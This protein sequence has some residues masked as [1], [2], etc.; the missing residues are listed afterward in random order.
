MSDLVAG[1]DGCRGG[2]IVALS[3][4]ARPDLD[5]FRI[6]TLDELF[7]RFPDINVVAVDMPI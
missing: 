6:A 5:I 2:W 4:V 3:D 7:A 1:V